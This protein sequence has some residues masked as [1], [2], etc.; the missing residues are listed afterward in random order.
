MQQLAQ[1]WPK[2]PNNMAYIAVVSL[3]SNVDRS[4]TQCNPSNV[5]VEQ[6]FVCRVVVQ[7]IFKN[8]KKNKK[9][10]TKCKSADTRVNTRGR[11]STP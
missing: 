6:T 7:L 11:F 9:I 8:V 1:N 2:P 5:Y 3:L 4:C 10:Y